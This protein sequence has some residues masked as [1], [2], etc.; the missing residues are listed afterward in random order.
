[1]EGVGQLL[2]IGQDRVFARGKNGDLLAFDKKTGHPIGSIAAP[3]YGMC[4]QNSLTDRLYLATN[5]GTLLCLRETDAYYPTIFRPLP[6]PPQEQQKPA[7][8][9]RPATGTSPAQP[10]NPPAADGGLFGDDMFGG[11]LGEE[12][13][14]AEQPPQAEPPAE[15][16]TDQA[17][18]E[19]EFDDPFDFG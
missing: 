7:A 13:P 1:M 9:E 15:E 5:D 12:Q 4:Y 14:A 11:D 18:P 8:G 2:A 16:A 10:A 3:A 6:E 19:E 17:A